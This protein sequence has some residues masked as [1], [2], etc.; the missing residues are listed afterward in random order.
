ML[1][2]IT[3]DATNSLFQPNRAPWDVEIDHQPAKLQI[4][5]LAGG[6][7]RD[8]HLRAL[9]KLTFRIDA[10]TRR[11]SIADSHTAMNLRDTQAPLDELAKGTPILS[12][13]RQ[14]IERV[15]VLRKNEQLHLWVVED[16]LLVEQGVQL[17][18]LGMDVPSFDLLGVFSELCQF[19][20]FFAENRWVIRQNLIFEL[21]DYRL[22]FFF[23]HVVEI[24]RDA[25][26]DLL[27][28]ILLRVREDFLATVPHAFQA[29]SYGVNR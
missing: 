8:Q 3:V 25:T 17:V 6:F 2:A 5:S 12:I 24:V 13:S 16:A 19:G 28:A 18:E 14:K 27:L 15:L 20:D 23:I 21:R 11:I 26:L 10:R 1:L 22:L 9:A 7:R 29:S 4:D